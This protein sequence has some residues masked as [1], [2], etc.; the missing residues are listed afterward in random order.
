MELKEAFPLRFPLPKLA[1]CGLVPET[2]LLTLTDMLPP[3]KCDHNH[4]KIQRKQ[5]HSFIQHTFSSFQFLSQEKNHSSFKINL[6]ISDTP[7]ML[8]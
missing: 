5:P 2:N 4:S 1:E 8:C 3:L 7:S 6:L